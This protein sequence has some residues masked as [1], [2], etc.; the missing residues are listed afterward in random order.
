MEALA[1]SWKAAWERERWGLLSDKILLRLLVRVLMENPGVLSV[2][3]HPTEG[4]LPD[5]SED[6]VTEAVRW[7]GGGGFGAVAKM[8][9]RCYP[10]EINAVKVVPLRSLLEPGP[11]AGGDEALRN[12]VAAMMQLRHDNIVNILGLYRFAGAFAP[13][14]RD[15]PPYLCIVM[16]C[17]EGLPLG[18]LI[19]CPRPDV[20]KQIAP[21]LVSA[22]EYMHSQ[23]ICH[24][25]ISLNNVLMNSSGHATIVDLGLAA[26]TGSS[27]KHINARYASPETFSS[28][29][30]PVSGQVASP[31]LDCWALGVVLGE[32]ASGEKASS[33]N[34]VV[35]GS[36]EHQLLV[37]HLE[38]LMPGAGRLLEPLPERRLT[39]REASSLIA[40]AMSGASAA[41][42]GSLAAACV[43]AP[44]AAVGVPLPLPKWAENLQPG[45]A[46][47]YQAR[48]AAGATFSGRIARRMPG[49]WEVELDA[50]ELDGSRSVRLVEDADVSLRL[51]LALPGMN[52]M[53]AT[54][55]AA[56]AGSVIRQSSC[57]PSWIGQAGPSG[58]HSPGPLPTPAAP[59]GSVIRQSSSVP[60]WVGQAG[61]SGGHSPG[62]L[63]PRAICVS[64]GPAGGSF[65]PP[66]S[67]S[68]I[69][70]A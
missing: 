5:L 37:Q 67:C 19:Q 27:V 35:P 44:A 23:G 24:R 29:L 52:A 40:I 58:G 10:F 48:R 51:S 20:A 1:E 12:E 21:Q 33:I 55:P 64:G 11:A 45:Q 41:S 62:P 56:P 38:V 15:A 46:V 2:I 65:V 66:S 36:F 43:A 16:P 17:I 4:F 18:S 25:D 69:F 26:S 60:S 3:G 50:F 34:L 9:Q 68:F 22:L 8:Q 53:A 49:A 61:P 47:T 13:T 32:V 14:S 54:T 7:V 28:P 42:G 30:Q 63:P 59:A 39:M 6:Y 57:V 31:S 70:A